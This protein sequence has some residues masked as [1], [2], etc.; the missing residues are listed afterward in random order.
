[1]YKKLVKTKKYKSP[2]KK[3]RTGKIENNLLIIKTK[4]IINY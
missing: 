3:N 4:L 2:N 1:M